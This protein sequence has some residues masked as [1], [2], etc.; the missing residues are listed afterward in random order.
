[1]LNIS[2]ILQCSWDNQNLLLNAAEFFVLKE[3]K[4]RQSYS[5]EKMRT[6]EHTDYPYKEFLP[7][8]KFV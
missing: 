7:L 1:M 8:D 5:E 3:T 2:A 6:V 4:K